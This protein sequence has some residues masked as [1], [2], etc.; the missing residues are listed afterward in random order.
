MG[1]RPSAFVF[2]QIGPLRLY[3]TR[4]LLALP[5]PEWLIDGI[6]TEG[7]VAG[8]YGAPEAGKSFL[9]IDMALCIAAGIP[10]QGHETQKGFVLYIS[11]EGGSGVGK[12]ALAWLLE[13]QIDP[14]EADVA[15]LIESIPVNADSEQ[16][17]TLMERIVNE[18]RRHPVLIVV[19]TLAR[20]FDGDENQQED[21]GRFVAGIDILRQEF[22]CTV[23]VVHHTNAGGTRER[24]NTAFRGAADTMIRIEK[25]D[26]AISLICDKQKD[27][28]HFDDHLFE[29]TVI[30]AA[31]SCVLRHGGATATQTAVALLALLPEGGL[32]WVDWQARA[33]DHEIDGRRFAQA[34]GTLRYQKKVQKR[35]DSWARTDQ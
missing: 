18:V 17:I 23:M 30:A 13:H 27:A 28:A 3:S 33:Q 7:G 8:M 11:A 25:T 21:M 12:R 16:M 14:R 29:L 26:N 15:W 35:G 24:G 9:A 20:C 34:F 5:P 32:T 6:I 2:T 31:D 19:D 1:S 4:E 10:W 22:G